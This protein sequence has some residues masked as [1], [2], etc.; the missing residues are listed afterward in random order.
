MADWRSDDRELLARILTA[1][2][3][4]QGPVGMLAAGNV[5][6][7]RA[8]TTGYG[9]SLRGVIMKPGQ[10]SPMNSVTGYAGGEQGQ[11]IDAL[12][13]SETAYM[14]ADTLL[15]GNAKDITGGATH[16]Y[17]PDISSPSW[18][19]GQDFIRIGDHVFGR[20]DAG[21]GATPNTGA[22]TMNQPMQPQQMP[23]QEQPRGLRGLLS[24]PDFFD[25]LAIG[26]SG[27]TL[28]P[29]TQLM[30]MAAD[31]ISGRREERQTT[32]TR[33][34]TA[35]WLRSQGRDDLAD[36]VMSGALGGREAAT[37]AYQQP[38]DDRTAVMRNY[39]FFLSQGMTPEQAMNAVRSGNVVNMGGTPTI[40]P[41]PAGYQA[42]Q[43][44]QT[45]EYTFKPIEGGPA[46]AEAIAAS[47]RDEMRTGLAESAAN[48]V[49]T[50]AQRARQAAA[51]RRVGGVLG[52]LAAMNP[53]TANAEIVR[54]VGTLQSMAAAENINAMRQASPTGGALGNASDADILLL[55]QKSGALDPFS[56][57]FERDLDDYERTLLRTI[58][59]FEEGNRIYEATRD[60][61]LLPLNGSAGNSVDG[62]IVG[63]PYQ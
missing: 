55:Q 49:I 43:D 6:M 15:S 22:E 42:V 36:A 23:Q 30:Q 33:N 51:N 5:I 38:E 61:M 53:A 11:N 46:A 4:N 50:A 41:I 24:D 60:G 19:E 7:N 48:I 47:R 44:P 35:E 25:R 56:P 28:N 13:P 39:E 18:A 3:G 21:R 14:V 9:D 52:P 26:L 57:N 62:V 31:R 37:I 45:G 12:T 27:M 40:G 8:N 17:N 34:R 10:F 32:E 1:E 63:E 54:Q 29:N 20:A 16:F 58:H 59:G 2:A